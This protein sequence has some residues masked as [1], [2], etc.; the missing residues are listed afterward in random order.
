MKG[1]VT[2]KILQDIDPDIVFFQGRRFPS[3]VVRAAHSLHIPIISHE[4]D[5][6]PGLANKLCVP[7][8]DLI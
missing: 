5:I 2:Q 7:M 8:V 4:S 3:L 1:E 6:T